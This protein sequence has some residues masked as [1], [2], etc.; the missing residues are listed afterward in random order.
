M[1]E[2]KTIEI[3]DNFIKFWKY[4]KKNIDFSTDANY[5]D[6]KKRKIPKD[7]FLQNLTSGNFMPIK[8]TENKNNFNYMLLDISEWQNIDI[9]QTLISE[10]NNYLKYHKLE[11][12]LLFDLEINKK[13]LKDVNVFKTWFIGCQKC[14]EERE[15]LNELCEIYKNKI[16]FSSLVNNKENEIKN[17]ILKH[18]IKY[19]YIIKDKMFFENHL[20]I[21]NFPIYII[22]DKSSKIIKI[23]ED[24]YKVNNYLIK[25]N[26]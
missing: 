18:F 19:D 21:N 9:K 17:H 14:E 5:Y 11:G 26:D 2:K 1:L 8:F 22:T 20:G 13:N 4:Y 24:V 15:Y 16:Y 10:S 3:D 7:F 23:F 12:K 6:I 25:L